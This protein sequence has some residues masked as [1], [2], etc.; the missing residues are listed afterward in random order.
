MACSKEVVNATDSRMSCNNRVVFDRILRKSR[1]TR[2]QSRVAEPHLYTIF[3]SLMNVHGID[4]AT[5]KTARM[6][7]SPADAASVCSVVSAEV[8]ADGTM[9]Q[10]EYE[11]RLVQAPSFSIAFVQ[12]CVQFCFSDSSFFHFYFIV[13]R[14]LI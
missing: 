1:Y 13:S 7:Y 3:S 12:V 2:V 11:E 9:P 14:F 10:A 6:M 8:P 4:P 5:K